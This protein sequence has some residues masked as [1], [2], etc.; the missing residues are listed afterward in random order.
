MTIINAAEDQYEAVRNFYHSLIDA[1]AGSAAFVGWKK[2]IYPSP[3]FLKRAAARGEMYLVMEAEDIAAAMVL[4]R[5]CNDGYAGFRW[6]SGARDSEAM[7]I[8]ALGVHPRYSGRG[9]AKALVRRA[10]AVAAEHGMKAV[11]LDVLEGNYPAEKLY[12]GLGFRYMGTVKMYY[13]DTGW[14]DF[15]LYEYPIP[16]EQE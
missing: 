5:E 6:Q 12:T 4:N 7:V 10:F 14:K 1:M 16:A 11:R 13:E 8:H 15:M 9:Y 2:D 3:E